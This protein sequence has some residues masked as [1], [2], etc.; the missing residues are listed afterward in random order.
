MEM[1]ADVTAVEGGFAQVKVSGGGGCG[2]CH[3]AGGCR[4]GVLTQ[5]F[6]RN[7]EQS[8]RLPNAIQAR[9]G[10]RVV[11]SVQDGLTA[12]TALMVYIVP[13][14][15]VLFGAAVGMGLAG[16]SGDAPAL[17]GAGAGLLL[18]LLLVARF[19][20]HAARNA[21]FQPVMVRRAEGRSCASHPSL[22]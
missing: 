15:G 17:L 10:E 8:F 9:V 19:R 12:K 21:Q 6:G 7:T 11:L 4:S 3:E 20:R 18:S 5:F 13:V 14:L 2:R 22:S 1:Q 16:H